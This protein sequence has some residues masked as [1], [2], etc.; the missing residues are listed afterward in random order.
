MIKNRLFLILCFLY[1]MA[2]VLNSEDRYGWGTREITPDI[3]HVF[4]VGDGIGQL[5]CN[6]AMGTSDTNPH[7]FA[8][9]QEGNLYVDDIVNQRMVIFDPDFNYVRSLDIIGG[10]RIRIQDDGILCIS[11]GQIQ[12]Y[13]FDGN[14]LFTVNLEKLKYGN[15]SVLDQAY[16]IDSYL[17]FDNDVYLYLRNGEVLSIDNPTNNI[18]ENQARLVNPNNTIN[19][20]ERIAAPQDDSLT[21]NKNS[22]PR[23]LMPGEDSADTMLYN[24]GKPIV[25]DSRVFF[26]LN[27]N[28]DVEYRP[29]GLSLSVLTGPQYVTPN[30]SG[31]QGA[32]PSEYYQ[33]LLSGLGYYGTDGNGYTYWWWNKRI[34]I[35]DKDNNLYDMFSLPFSNT[36]QIAVT[37]LG[38]VYYLYSTEE[39]HLLC[40][41]K[42]QW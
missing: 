12:K 16:N 42:R 28:E 6:D 29:Q 15:M 3:I 22:D 35:F 1:L 26:G 18:Q 13:D 24:D 17:V 34:F 7:G 39:E 32:I 2:N 38:N 36:S 23:R 25:H 27:R 4:P 10:Q 31:S 37:S 40:E 41:I 30:F 21:M 14:Q 8:F 33:G 11:H 19:S 9:D 5:G 20:L